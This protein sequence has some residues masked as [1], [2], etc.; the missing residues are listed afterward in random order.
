ME[1][2]FKVSKTKSDNSKLVG[3]NM[4]LQVHSYLTLYS[5]AK[6][7][8]KT[9]IIKEL[10]TNWIEKQ[11]AKEEDWMLIDEIVRRVNVKWGAIKEQS[12]TTF[13]QFKVTLRQELLDRG[14]EERNIKSILQKLKV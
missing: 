12:D 8:T 6:G 9:L 7:T 11:R 1:S 10:L 13:Q 2:I 5:L 14:I 3:A 4:P